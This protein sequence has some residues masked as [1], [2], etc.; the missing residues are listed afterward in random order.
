MNDDSFRLADA[1]QW[2]EQQL[3]ARPLLERAPDGCFLRDEQ[4]VKLIL[5][6]RIALTAYP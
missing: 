1:A 6:V 2:K 5:I 3:T 4:V